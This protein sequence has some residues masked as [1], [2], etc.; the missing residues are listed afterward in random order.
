[1]LMIETLHDGVRAV[2]LRHEGV[3]VPA[4]A[5]DNSRQRPLMRGI[6]PLLH[7]QYEQGMDQVIFAASTPPQQAGQ[8][9]HFIDKMISVIHGPEGAYPKPRTQRFT[10]LL[11]ATVNRVDVHRSHILFI[12]ADID[13]ARDASLSQVKFVGLRNPANEEDFDRNKV[14]SVAS[15]DELLR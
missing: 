5:E 4:D 7:R 12:G 15:L 10:D 2:I 3:I 1:M 9:A 6:V 11:K 8:E 14:P 13:D